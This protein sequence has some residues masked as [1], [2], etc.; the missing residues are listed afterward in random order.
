MRNKLLFILI[1][2]S[3]TNSKAQLVSETVIGYTMY[4]LQ[5]NRSTYNRIVQNPDGTVSAVWNFSPDSS[6]IFPSRGTGY[7]YYDGITWGA[8]PTSRTETSRTGFTNIIS[9]S[10]GKELSIA[11]TLQGIGVNFRPTKGTGAW[12]FSQ[13]WGIQG[14]DSWVKAACSGDS[15][16][17]IWSGIGAVGGQV[18][19]QFGPIYFSASYDGGQT[20]SAKSIITL[21]DSAHYIGWAAERYAIDAKGG[22]VAILYGDL[23]TDLGILK[24][25]DGGQT[26]TQTLVQTHPI[27]NYGNYITPTDTNLDG[28]ID[29]LHS[30]SGDETILI[31]NNGMCHV[32]FSEFRWLCDGGGSIAII[33]LYGSDGLSYWNESMGSDNYIK[34]ATMQDFNLNG[35]ID[36]AVNP[37]ICPSF[38][39]GGSYFSITGKPSAG[40]DLNGTIYLVYQTMDETS[41]TSTWSVLHTHCF[42]KTLPQIAGVYNVNN[43]T[44][45]F[46]I[47]RSTVQGGNDEFEE[48]VF[49][50]ITKYIDQ[51]AYVVYQRDLVPNVRTSSCNATDSMDSYTNDIV[52]AKIE[53]ATVGVKSLKH[54]L[55]DAIGISPN[56]SHQSFLLQFTLN[57]AS[58]VRIELIDWIGKI[59]YS[60]SKENMNVGTT[61]QEISTTNLAP[62]IYTCSVISN[63]KRVASKVVVTP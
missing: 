35:R 32:W 34:I 7:N 36:F 44:Y 41:D 8:W 31:D 10:S 1:I 16:Y 4:D 6:A 52:V 21:L 12:N 43:W 30:P 63:G 61:K 24:S 17:A 55:I 58:D 37:A 3:I 19:G 39:Q 23:R 29:T 14:D 5:Y 60:K 18:A 28:I 38:N 48:C 9:T 25:N 40:I 45:P 11:H 2:F 62:G 51:Y 33:D 56:P 46:S 13:P 22:I 42:I 20:W 15:V 47:S 27:P 26:W 49:P 57:Q 54:N 59:V 53:A 50:S